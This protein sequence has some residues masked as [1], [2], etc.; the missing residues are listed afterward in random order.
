MKRAKEYAKQY[1]DEPTDKVLA[2]IAVAFLAEIA[3]LA[4]T[5][6]GRHPSHGAVT[7]IF[8]EQD[9]K[10][11]AFAENFPGIIRPDGFELLLKKR[12]PEAYLLWQGPL[13]ELAE[14]Q[15]MKT[16]KGAQ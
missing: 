8:D 16:M 1:R 15:E 13:A 14:R 6:L 2:K 9:R 11:R 4:E 10:W 3:E 12:E 5:R 7:A